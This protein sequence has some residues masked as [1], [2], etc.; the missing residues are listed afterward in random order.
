[1]LLK[2]SIVDLRNGLGS[3]VRWLVVRSKTEHRIFAVCCVEYLMVI[4]PLK[5]IMLIWTMSLGPFLLGDGG[6]LARDRELVI[7]IWVLIRSQAMSF[8]S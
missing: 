4:G 3:W 6:L 2:I 8:T 7:H 1:M 5:R